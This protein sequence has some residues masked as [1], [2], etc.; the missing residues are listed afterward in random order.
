MMTEQA[1]PRHRLE[2]LTRSHLHR[3]ARHSARTHVNAM[4]KHDGDT[5]DEPDLSAP[6]LP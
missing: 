3:A 1:G 6:M 2:F 4:P 5:T